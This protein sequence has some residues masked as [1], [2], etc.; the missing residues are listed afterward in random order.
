VLD[1]IV[2]PTPAGHG[3]RAGDYAALP[4]RPLHPDKP[5]GQ[6]RGEIDVRL[7]SLLVPMD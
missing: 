6:V 1:A 3:L 5:D 7:V 4:R 2:R